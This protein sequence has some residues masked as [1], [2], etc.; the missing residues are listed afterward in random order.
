MPGFVAL[1]Q[2]QPGFSPEVTKPNEPPVE[3]ATNELPSADSPES[4]LA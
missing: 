3:T 2:D 4:V 1:L